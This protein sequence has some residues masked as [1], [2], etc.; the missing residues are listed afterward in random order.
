MNEKKWGT[1]TRT[2]RPQ[3][4]RPITVFKETIQNGW[5]KQQLV[6]FSP[7]VRKNG[8]SRVKVLIEG[9]EK[10]KGTEKGLA[11]VGGVGE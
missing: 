8:Q 2:E 7:Q 1:K 4:G 11:V 3:K 6:R 10:G 5:G 9:G